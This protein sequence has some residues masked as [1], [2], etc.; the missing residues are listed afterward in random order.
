MISLQD[1]G[2]HRLKTIVTSDVDVS[3]AISALHYTST[4]YYCVHR[5]PKHVNHFQGNIPQLYNLNEK[6]SN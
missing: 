5:F 2:A 3:G 6:I 1:A 4:V